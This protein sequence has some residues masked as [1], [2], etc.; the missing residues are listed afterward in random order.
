MPFRILPL[1]LCGLLAP[2]A[3]AA[4]PGSVLAAEARSDHPYASFW[5]GRSPDV[6]YITPMAAMAQIKRVAAARD[7]PYST[8]RRLVDDNTVDRERVDVAALN[9]ALDRLATNK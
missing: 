8:V 7:L 2:A 3:S 9:R 5:G 4:P 6:R 1:L